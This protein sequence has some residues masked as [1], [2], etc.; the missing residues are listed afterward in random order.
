MVGKKLL[1][2]EQIWIDSELDSIREGYCLALLP[3]DTSQAGARLLALPHCL[4]VRE[5]ADA[6]HAV[7]EMGPNECRAHL[8]R[9]FDLVDVNCRPLS[10][11]E[12]FIELVGGTS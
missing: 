10:L 6:V 12:M 11:E 9:E 8:T 1:E 4:C 7:F 2:L 3:A 5:R